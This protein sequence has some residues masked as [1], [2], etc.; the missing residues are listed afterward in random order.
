MFWHRKETHQEWVARNKFELAKWSLK[1]R[2][3][4]NHTCQACGYKPKKEKGEWESTNKLNAHHIIP[5]WKS[6]SLAFNLKNGITLCDECHTEGKHAYH[7]LYGYKRGSKRLFYRWLRGVRGESY[8][9]NFLTYFAVMI[10]V[11]IV[12]ILLIGV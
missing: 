4:D 9:I 3:R 5:K 1:V 6:H 10:F 12:F 7:R 11:I 2:A 8:K